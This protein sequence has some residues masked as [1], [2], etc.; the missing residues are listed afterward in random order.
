M[1]D[2]QKIKKL[3]EAIRTIL[4]FVPPAYPMPMGWDKIVN[5]VENLLKSIK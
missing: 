3:K 2:T 1:T 4:N 5:Q